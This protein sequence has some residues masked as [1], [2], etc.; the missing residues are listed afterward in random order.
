MISGT[1]ASCAYGVTLISF[2][3]IIYFP[4]TALYVINTIIM[5]VCLLVVIV[6]RSNTSI[7][8]MGGF[9]QCISW[10]KSTKLLLRKAPMAVSQIFLVTIR[11][12]HEVQASAFWFC[13]FHV[14]AVT[15]NNNV[16]VGGVPRSAWKLAQEL[17]CSSVQSLMQRSLLWT[18]RL[19][20]VWIECAI[21]F[22][23]CS[24]PPTLLWKW[25][26]TI[27]RDVYRMRMNKVF[28]PI[29]PTPHCR[30]FYTGICTTYLTYLPA[31][32]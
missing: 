13:R 27:V 24:Q 3:F 9:V 28:V 2:D 6:H 14:I 17:P 12:A 31:S 22:D 4:V 19:M 32:H 18:V 5:S 10:G 20:L 23:Y 30:H 16:F 21:H 8:R 25:R 11:G 29:V 15:E 7:P 1:I 26:H